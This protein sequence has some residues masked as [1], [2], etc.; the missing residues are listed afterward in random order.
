[1]IATFLDRCRSGAGQND[2]SQPVMPADEEHREQYGRYDRTEQSVAA[3]GVA[4]DGSDEGDS[5]VD[6]DRNPID[7]RQVE[8]Q[9]WH[10]YDSP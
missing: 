5:R 2:A 8:R 9:I 10:A 4:D 3:D 6:G 7:G 1:M